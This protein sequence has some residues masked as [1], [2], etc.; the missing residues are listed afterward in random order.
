MLCQKSETQRLPFYDKT[1]TVYE[2][3][4][5]D[6][7]QEAQFLCLSQYISAYM[8]PK[9]TVFQFSVQVALQDYMVFIA[10][11]TANLM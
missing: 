1:V 8:I 11:G 9:K 3:Q 6:P 4:T 5:F 10:P 2:A 7:C